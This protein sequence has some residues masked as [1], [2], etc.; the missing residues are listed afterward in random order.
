MADARPPSYP[1][2]ASPNP[3]ATDG[4]PRA[5]ATYDADGLPATAVDPRGNVEG[6]NPDDFTWTYGYDGAGSLTG[7]TDPLGHTQ[8]SACGERGS[9]ERGRWWDTDPGDVFRER[10]THPLPHSGSRPDRRRDQEVSGQ[11]TGALHHASALQSSNTSSTR[12]CLPPRP[13]TRGGGVYPCSPT[14][15]RRPGTPSGTAPRPRPGSW[16]KPPTTASPYW[17]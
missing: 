14:C 5:A 13:L 11:V 17:R 10:A 15:G 4:A 8:T 16:S 1:R 3:A 6:A 2:G 9:G 7:V 12:R